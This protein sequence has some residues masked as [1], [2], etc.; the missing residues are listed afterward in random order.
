MGPTG[1]L[2]SAPDWLKLLFL[3]FQSTYKPV[4]TKLC[5]LR[6]KRGLGLYYSCLTSSGI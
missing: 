5:K 4:H 1:S 2:G 6:L 3:T